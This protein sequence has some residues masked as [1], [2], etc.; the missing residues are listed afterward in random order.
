MALRAHPRERGS[1]LILALLT[2]AAASIAGM[3]LVLTA[4]LRTRASRYLV[5]SADASRVAL[6]GLQ[7]AR[8]R[9]DA[10][11]GWTGAV[12]SDPVDPNEAVTVDASPI[13]SYMASVTSIGAIGDATQTVTADLRAVAHPALTFRVVSATTLTFSDA[14][15]GGYLRA[16]GDVEVLG[17]LDFYGALVTTEG[18]VVDGSVPS[19]QVEMVPDDLAPPAVSLSEYAALS[20]PLVGVPSEDGAFVLERVA[21]R[22]D[23]NPYGGTHPSGAYTFDAGGVEVV[24]RD[25]FVAGCLTFTSCPKVTIE[26]GYHHERVDAGLASLLCDGDLDVV[27]GD[28]LS[29]LV[30]LMDFDGDGDLLGVHPAGI[31]G[32]VRVG[33]VFR[34]G[35]GGKIAGTLVANEVVLAG[36]LELGGSTTVDSQPVRGFIEPGPWDVVPGSVG[37]GAGG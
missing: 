1:I 18:S 14:A 15:V 20:S 35:G 9:L 23:A 11:P 34:G 2:S 17:S 36:A 7:L 28:D 30:F 29:E 16:N 19:G 3:Y 37:K 24:L 32:V 25:V 27:F 5:R 13:G 6:S 31:E 8:H 26:R 10:A 33:G 12:A 4:D 21:F 22:P